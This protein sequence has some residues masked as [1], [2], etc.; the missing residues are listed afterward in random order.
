MLQ[1]VLNAGDVLYIPQHWW[2]HVRSL[3]CPNIAISLWFHAF[4]E[5]EYDSPDANEESDVGTLL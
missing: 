1:V 4:P 5:K 3:E 2:H